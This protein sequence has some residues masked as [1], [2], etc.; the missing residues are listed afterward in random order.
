MEVALLI[1]CFSEKVPTYLASYPRRSMFEIHKSAPIAEEGRLSAPKFP[2]GLAK[3][4]LEETDGGFWRRFPFLH[5]STFRVIDYFSMM[6]F[7]KKTFFWGFG[8]YFYF[9]RFLIKINSN[10]IIIILLIINEV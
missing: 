8:F 5:R 6:I 2:Q 3:T 10:L 4:S 1:G 9:I 7:S